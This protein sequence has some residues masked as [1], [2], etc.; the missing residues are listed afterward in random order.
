MYSRLKMNVLSWN[1]RVKREGV[2]FWPEVCRVQQ[3]HIS[4]GLA[5]G[6]V[7]FQ[8]RQ[9]KWSLTWIPFLRYQ[10]MKCIVISPQFGPWQL[11][12]TLITGYF[13]RISG[14]VLEYCFEG[15]PHGFTRFA[16]QEACSKTSDGNWTFYALTLVY[17]PDETVKGVHRQKEVFVPLW[18]FGKFS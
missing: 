8:V 5:S 12:L 11:K 2:T 1:W 16:L 9:R 15:L 3:I 4:H 10:R 13:W 7:R 6:S 14:R 18:G 17:I